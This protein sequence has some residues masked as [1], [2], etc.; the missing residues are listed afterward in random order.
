MR[1]KKKIIIYIIITILVA[2]VIMAGTV[3]ILGKIMPKP[4]AVNISPKDKGDS[5]KAQATEALNNNDT[6]KATTLIKQAQDQYKLANYQ[7]GV[8]DTDSMLF[9]IDHVYNRTNKPSG[10]PIPTLIDKKP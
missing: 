9:I 8:I 6:A 1:S 10:D 4:Q 3:V 5:L 7:S 2:T